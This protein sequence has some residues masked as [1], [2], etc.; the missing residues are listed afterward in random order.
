MAWAG[1]NLV[2]AARGTIARV[3]ELRRALAVSAPILWALGVRAGSGWPAAVHAFPVLGVWHGPLGWALLGLAA[4]LVLSGSG[5]VQGLPTPRASLLFWLGLLLCAGVG[6]RYATSLRASGDE[7]HYLVM[8][9]SLWREHDLDLR[10][11]FERE[12][13]REY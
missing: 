13:Y 10:D 3:P 12:D 7:P 6:V 2:R 1:S 5:V 4:V 8:A 9:Q 11:N